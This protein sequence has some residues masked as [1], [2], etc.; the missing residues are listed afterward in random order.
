MINYLAGALECFLFLYKF[1]YLLFEAYFWSTRCCIF[2]SSE[3]SQ[4]WLNWLICHII[5]RNIFCQILFRWTKF[6]AYEIS[7]PIILVPVSFLLHNNNYDVNIINCEHLRCYDNRPSLNQHSRL[8]FTCYTLLIRIKYAINYETFPSVANRRAV[9][10]S[11][12]IIYGMV[13]AM[14]FEI[15][16]NA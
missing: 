6:S 12:L 14:F 3:L 4:W 10:L 7:N 9:K 16:E 1:S 2:T 8:K 13:R 15:F 11:T 5:V